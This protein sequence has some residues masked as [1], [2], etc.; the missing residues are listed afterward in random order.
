MAIRGGTKG[1]TSFILMNYLG[2]V[3]IKSSGVL[4]ILVWLVGISIGGRM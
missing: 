4:I 2:L 3:K 1:Q